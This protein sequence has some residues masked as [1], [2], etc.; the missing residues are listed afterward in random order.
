M[1]MV[2]FRIE[3]MTGEGRRMVRLESFRAQRA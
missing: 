2:L 1:V 3:E